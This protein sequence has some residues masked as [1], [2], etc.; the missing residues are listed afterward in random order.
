[1]TDARSASAAYADASNAI[2]ARGSRMLTA[3]I[4]ALLAAVADLLPP[5]MS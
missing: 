2:I 3:L 4:I 5:T 1:L